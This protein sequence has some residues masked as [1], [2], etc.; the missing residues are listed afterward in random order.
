MHSVIGKIDCNERY[1]SSRV[2]HLINRDLEI[3]D[4]YVVFASFGGYTKKFIDS[5]KGAVLDN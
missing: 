3:T 1:A 4:N 2:S 5:W